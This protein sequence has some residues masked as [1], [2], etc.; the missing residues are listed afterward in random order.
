MG[1]MCPIV[2]RKT[3]YQQ[4]QE[5]EDRYCEKDLFYCAVYCEEE[6]KHKILLYDIMDTLFIN[7]PDVVIV[8][9]RNNQTI[10]DY[11]VRHD[12]LYK[13][14]ENPEKYILKYKNKGCVRIN[15]AHSLENEFS[16]EIPIRDIKI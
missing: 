10:K 3:T 11:A 4:C 14:V 15:T 2:D 8:T 7:Y 16:G 9:D 1:K 5:C 12:F 13:V 6:V